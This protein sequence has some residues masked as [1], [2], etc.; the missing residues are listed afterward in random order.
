METGIV[1]QEKHW[2]YFA[3]FIRYE[4]AVGGPDPHMVLVGHMS[5][6][7]SWHERVWHGICYVSVYNTPTAEALWRTWPWAAVVDNR[8]RLEVWL[9][10]HWKGIATRR[11]RR[12]VRSAEKL[13]HCLADGAEW[14]QRCEPFFDI[15]SPPS[16]ARYETMWN[17]CQ[18][19]YALG[20]YA[21]IKLLEYFGRYCGL[22]SRMPDMRARGGWSPRE[23][24]AMLY[25]EHASVLTGDDSEATLR[26]VDGL[27]VKGR[28]FLLEKYGLSL[29]NF[30]FQVMLCDYKQSYVGRRQYPGRSHDSELEYARVVSA[31]FGGES[32]MWATRR[33]LFP[34]RALGEL[35]GWSGVRKELG[36]VLRDFGY[37]WSDIRFSY[38]ASKD[39]LAH[40]V[41]WE[42]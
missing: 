2:D 36:G 19:I 18:R 6:D 3:E 4:M 30:L 28:Q 11:E 25:P 42:M 12:S 7:V 13:A 26:H 1:D 17:S 9:R 39:D 10:T 38:L 14:V 41:A 31:H 23:A 5:E 32:D 29:D 40:P 27:A 20:R 33:R 15:G 16:L 37:T 21:T 24:L 34:S 22:S 8:E 35:S